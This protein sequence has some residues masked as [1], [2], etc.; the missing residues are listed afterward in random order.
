MRVF[1]RGT[2]LQSVTAFGDWVFF[3]ACVAISDDVNGL[4]RSSSD[5]LHPQVFA[6]LGD[7][8]TTSVGGPTT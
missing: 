4:T 1:G 6:S 2:C 8:N 5:F 3:L 7:L